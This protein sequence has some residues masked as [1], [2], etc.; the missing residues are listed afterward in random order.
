[1]NSLQCL[2]NELSM[3]NNNNTNR[4]CY[5]YTNSQEEFDMDTLKHFIKICDLCLMLLVVIAIGIQYFQI[6]RTPRYI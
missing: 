2:N 3:Y 1:M 6:I 5:C 4:T